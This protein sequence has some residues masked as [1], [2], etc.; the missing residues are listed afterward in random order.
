MDKWIFQVF[1]SKP[2]LEGGG[3]SK[4]RLSIFLFCA[5]NSLIGAHNC[6]Y[7]VRM[8]T[9]SIL[10]PL[11]KEF[12]YDEIIVDLDNLKAPTCLFAYSKFVA[13]E[14]EPIGTICMDIDVILK[15]PCL[16]NF[17]IDKG[18]DVILQYKEVAAK[19]YMDYYNFLKTKLA[20][21]GY[22]S[23]IHPF[24]NCQSNVGV[25]GFNNIELKEKYLNS[26]KTAVKWFVENNKI[27][28]YKDAVLDLILEQTE[29][30]YLVQNKN[31]MY[32]YS[33]FDWTYDKDQQAIIEQRDKIGYLHL[34]G[35]DKNDPEVIEALKKNAKQYNIKL[36]DKIN[37]F[38]NKI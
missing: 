37:N 31:V 38:I 7:K 28:E 15:K 27:N 18:F 34:Q 5:I 17:Y 32:I 26:Y 22:P 14:T 1:W 29:I 30:D 21:T 19:R 13:L 9:D 11:L 3:D 24:H 4:E 16:D 33:N 23:C 10:Y 12:G 20:I 25:I 8:H 36:Y 6:C 35:T 2:I